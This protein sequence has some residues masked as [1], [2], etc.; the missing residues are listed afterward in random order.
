MRGHGIGE[1]PKILE[2][3]YNISATAKSS[4]FKFGAQLGFGKDH[5]KITQKKN[6]RGPGLGKFPNFDVPL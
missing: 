1:L 3:N 4:D 5:H 6:V 2:F